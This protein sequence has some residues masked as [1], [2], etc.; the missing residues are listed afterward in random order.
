[1][2]ADHDRSL[3]FFNG[4]RT[5]GGVQVLARAGRSALCFDFGATP[6]PS[7]SLFSRA[8]PPPRKQ[9]PCRPTYGPGW[10]R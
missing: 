6:N 7:A 2:P 3:T 4:T 10:H 1:M 9:G 8:C 5:V